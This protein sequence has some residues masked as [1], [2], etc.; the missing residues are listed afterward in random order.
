MRQA[1]TIVS[2]LL[3]RG[4][5]IVAV[6][7]QIDTRVADHGQLERLRTLADLPRQTASERTR[8]SLR[9]ARVEGR[10]VGRPRV[11][12]PVERAREL[13]A[14]GHSLR[15]TAAILRVAVAT[16]PRALQSQPAASAPGF[17]PALTELP[18]LR[19][20]A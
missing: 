1:V 18:G 17:A 6:S 10:P 3:G 20:V 4:V 13:L 7:E 15:R 14:E 16:L 11:N 19:R 12:V 5:D 2:E 8:A 9:R